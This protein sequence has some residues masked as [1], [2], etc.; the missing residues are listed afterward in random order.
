M[1]FSVS[2]PTVRAK[3]VWGP[4]RVLVAFALVAVSFGLVPSASAQGRHRRQTPKVRAG[5]ANA[6][7]KRDKMDNDVA[8]RA[9]G[10]FRLGSADVIVTL[11]D[12]ADLPYAF[13]RYS[14]NG[15]LSVIHGYV[16]DQVP[17]SLLATLANSGS[18]HRVHINRPAHKHDALSSVAVNAN[19]VDLG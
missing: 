17:V 3:A 10:I 15:K 19:A 14:H 7:V 2:P 8:R 16:L 1:K 13:Q 5:L 18:I 12:G 6:F 4:R 11:E 9:N